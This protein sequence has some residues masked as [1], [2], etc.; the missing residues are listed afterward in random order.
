MSLQ[1]LSPAISYTL[2]VSLT[3]PLAPSF[4]VDNIMIVIDGEQVNSGSLASSGDTDTWFQDVLG[5]TVTSSLIYHLQSTQQKY[6]RVIVITI[7]AISYNYFISSV[8][9]KT[10]GAVESAITH[11]FDFITNLY[12]DD[13]DDEETIP[14]MLVNYMIARVLMKPL[15]FS[16]LS[17]IQIRSLISKSGLYQNVVGVN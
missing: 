15:I 11:I 9:T 7:G 16:T 13:K 3:A 12:L 2:D 10:A 1:Q 14:K 4:P 6:G 5:W 8:E 17:D